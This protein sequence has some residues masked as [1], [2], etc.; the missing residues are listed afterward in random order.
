MRDEQPV[1]QPVQTLVIRGD[2]TPSAAPVKVADA[3]DVVNPHSDMLVRGASDSVRQ[4]RI[5]NA[6]AFS[7]SSRGDAGAH[8]VFAN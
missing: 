3:R 1:L 4:V 8:F 5:D 7:D 2:T 6:S